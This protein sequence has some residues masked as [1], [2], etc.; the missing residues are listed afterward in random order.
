MVSG[1]VQISFLIPKAC[2]KTLDGSNFTCAWPRGT[3]LCERQEAGKGLANRLKWS[4][5]SEQPLF[6]TPMGYSRNTRH[7]ARFLL[8]HS[9]L[10]GMKT[11]QSLMVIGVTVLCIAAHN[12]ITWIFIIS[13]ATFLFLIPSRV[14]LNSYWSLTGILLYTEYSYTHN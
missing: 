12:L 1:H 11:L 13:S 4:Q 3:A 6:P 14:I 8:A 5:Q 7:L 2:K 9:A 10:N